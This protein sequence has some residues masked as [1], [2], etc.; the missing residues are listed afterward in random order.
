VA[1]K[2]DVPPEQTPNGPI[3]PDAQGYDRFYAEFDSPVSRQMREEAYGED[4]GQHSWVTAEELRGDIALL[5]LT[6]TSRV[7]DLGCGPCGP[8]TF[9]VGLVG[10]HG[11]G[12]DVSARAITAGR[13]RVTALGLDD[14]VTL[15]ESDLNETVPLPGGSCDAVMSLDVVL[16]LRD[17]AVLFREVA[18]VMGPGGRFLLT[19]A[20]VVTGAISD[21]EVRRRAVHGYTQFVAPGLNELLLERAGF[22]LIHSQDRTPGL[23]RSAQGRLAARRAHRAELEARDGLADRERQ[24]SYLQTVITLAERG[25]VSRMMYVVE[26]PRRER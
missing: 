18:R 16:H 17:R 21:E 4:I 13:A 5:E 12:A 26:S 25:S 3:E 19:D 6:R 23:L 9:V 7:L 20:G 24:D 14:R 15:H 11:I 8:L 2:G 10:C 22:R 1:T